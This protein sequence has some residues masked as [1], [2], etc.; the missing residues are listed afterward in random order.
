MEILMMQ[1]V[2]QPCD[3]GLL[4]EAPGPGRLSAIPALRGIDEDLHL[5]PHRLAHSAHTLDLPFGTG[6]LAE[7][8][9]DGAIAIQHMLTGRFRQLIER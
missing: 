2:F 3:A 9:L 8:E 5:C 6:L 1:W 4:Q 7:A